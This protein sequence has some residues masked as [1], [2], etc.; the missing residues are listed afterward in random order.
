MKKIYVLDTNIL[1]QTEGKAI[2]G[3]DDNI[4]VIPS[5]VLEELDNMKSSLG[6][7]GYA[8]RSTIKRIAAV[9]DFKKNLISEE[10]AE[11]E[12]GGRLMV[13]ND[14]HSTLAFDLPSGWDPKKPDNIILSIVSSL[15]KHQ[16][17]K[18]PVILVTNDISLQIKASI[19]GL[20]VQGYKN[21]QTK[22]DVYTGRNVLHVSSE[23]IDKLY[24]SQNITLDEFKKYM[25]IDDGFEFLP[26]SYWVF[27]S[28]VT[29]QSAL[30]FYSKQNFI[31][32]QQNRLSD[33]S[34]ISPKN[35]GQTFA[36]HAL[37]QSCDDIPLVLLKGIAG[38][39]KT[40]LS[41]AAGLCQMSKGMYDKIIITR[42]NQ[43]AD[44]D[45]G[46][47]PGT[48]EEKMSP[49]LAPF[50]DNLKFLMKFS[51]E[52]DEQVTYLLEDMMARGSIEIVSLAYI[53]GRSIPN[54]YIIID[55]SQNLSVT[56]AKTI[57]TRCGIGTKL[58]MLGDPD[59]I[60]NPK[61]D[62]ISNGLVYLSDR[63]KGSPLCA[64]LSFIDNEC[65]RS[66]L[67]TEAISRL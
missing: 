36:M 8:V 61:L 58:V 31:L 46:F 15:D 53:R 28:L 29:N 52:S 67:A 45:I 16:G 34:G 43:L 55:E 24:K 25:S 51:G 17:N 5:M 57:V 65:V 22:E 4:V 19:L 49:L 37:M 50:Y 63:F 41:L 18:T 2:L 54:A 26:N 33:V 20:E 42:S 32:I 9:K 10:G 13:Y 40:L 12:N 6:E 14:V 21:E 64:Q 60:D 27:K 38:S 62:K 11:L 66:S 1:I 30:A 56:Q 44:E 48:L 23:I 35:S 39:G 59:Q 3:F 47:L 7:K